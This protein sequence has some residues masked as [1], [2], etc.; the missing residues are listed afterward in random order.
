MEKRRVPWKEVEKYLKKYL[1]EIIEIEETKEQIHIASD[2]PDEFTSSNDTMTTKGAYGKAKANASQGVRELIRI[3]KK[4]S[5]TKNHKE[6]NR[7][8]RVKAGIDT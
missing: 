6:K 8:K 3:S 7:K 4:T 5:E 2:F 1:G